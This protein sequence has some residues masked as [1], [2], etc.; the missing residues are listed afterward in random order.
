[1]LVTF[2]WKHEWSYLRGGLTTLDRDYGMINNIHH[3]IGTHV[4]HQLFPQIPHY[5][6][7]EAIEAAKPVLRKCYREPDKSGPL[8]LHLLRILAKGMKEDHYVR[9]EGDV[10]YYKADPNLYGD[11]KRVSVSEYNQIETTSLFSIDNTEAIYTRYIALLQQL[12]FD[13][14]LH[15]GLML[16]EDVLSQSGKLKEAYELIIAIHVEVEP[17]AS[18][19]CGSLLSG[20]SE[21]MG[22][23]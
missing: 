5:H 16:L 12:I 14:Y 10:V 23:Y 6:L 11:I 4:I 22:L 8:P 20:C 13:I 19:T 7:V 15:A 9:D 2:I 21:N 3:D 1:M 18:S 17:H